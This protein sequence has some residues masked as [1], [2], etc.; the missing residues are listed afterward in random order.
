MT[1]WL[2]GFSPMSAVPTETRP[3]A[4]V[5]IREFRPGDYAELTDLYNAIEPDYPSTVEEVRHEDDQWDRTKHVQVRYVA[6]DPGTGSLVAAA[7]YSHMLWSFDPHRFGAWVGVRPERAGQ[8]IGAVLHDRLMEDF[9]ARNAKSLRAWARED[10]A[11]SVRFLERRGFREMEKAWE[12]RLH[13][14]TFEPSRFADR[15][16]VPEGIET[17][18]LAEELERDPNAMLRVYELGDAIGPDTP[19]IDPY[20][21]PGFETWLKHVQGPWFLPEAFFLAKDGYAYDGLSDLG[22]SE[23]DPDVA[24]TGFTGVRREYR[25]RGIA[26]ALKLRALSWAKAHGYREVRTWNSTRNAPMLGI[27]VA[28]GF[29]K[30]PVWITFAKDL[31][32][33]S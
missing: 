24:Y 4:P 19:R 9:R 5:A 6:T 21:S 30:Q 23:A 2:R 7:E 8:G 25:G 10:R 27:N 22:K 29:Q 33:G 18:T 32:E 20:T 16:R 15:A 11:D 12:S 28:L 1:P 26:W 3:R 17:V 31:S 14:P 13:M